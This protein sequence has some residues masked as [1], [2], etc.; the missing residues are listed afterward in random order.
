MVSFEAARTD[1]T[2]IS[3]GTNTT[4]VKSQATITV[5]YLFPACDYNVTL[6]RAI[7][8]GKTDSADV[9]LAFSKV[10]RDFQLEQSYIVVHR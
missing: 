3:M 10:K 1:L 8:R 7:L 5:W 6:Q 2:I 9:P 4:Y